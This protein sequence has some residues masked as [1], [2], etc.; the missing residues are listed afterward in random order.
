MTENVTDITFSNFRWISDRTPSPFL[1][2]WQGHTDLISL[3]N[4]TVERPWDV[5]PALIRL[6]AAPIATVDELAIDGLKFIGTRDR[7]PQLV[8]VQAPSYITRI[9]LNNAPSGYVNVVNDDALA[10][11]ITRSSRS[12]RTG[13]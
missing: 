13:K 6:E 2:V 10:G 11:T 7:L 5:V 3:K 12:A 1:R 8:L 4:L 9:N